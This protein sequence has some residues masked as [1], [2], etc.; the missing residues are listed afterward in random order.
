MLTMKTPVW[1]QSGQSQ[2]KNLAAFA[3][4]FVTC[5]R[6]FWS[7]C[8]HLLFSL[9]TLNRCHIFFYCVFCWLWTSKCLLGFSFNL[10]SLFK[11]GHEINRQKH[12]TGLQNLFKVKLT[13]N[14]QGSMMPT[15]FHTLHKSSYRWF[16]HL[17]G[18]PMDPKK[19]SVKDFLN[20]WV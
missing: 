5:V 7:N 6:P 20:K 12:Y 13:T 2:V 16:E 18:V 10:W 8:F 1:R 4:R 3:Q 19:S 9:L 17:T 15:K 11:S 14:E